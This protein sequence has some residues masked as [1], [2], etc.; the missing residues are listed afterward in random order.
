MPVTM[1]KTCGRLTNS[2][3]SNYWAR[4]EQDGGTEKVCGE[5]TACYAAFVDDHWVKGCSYDTISPFKQKMV[6]TLIYSDN[7]VGE[8]S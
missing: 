1:C 8:K 3:V 2:A 5:S 4:T 7:D 6:D